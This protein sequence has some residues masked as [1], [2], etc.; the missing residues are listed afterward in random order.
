MTNFLFSSFHVKK[1]RFCV[2]FTIL[3]FLQKNNSPEPN[4]SSIQENF[5]SI[6][7]STFTDTFF[8]V[9]FFAASFAVSF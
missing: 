1:Q 5:I 8:N 2:T 9:L 6:G 7:F 3:N 4:F